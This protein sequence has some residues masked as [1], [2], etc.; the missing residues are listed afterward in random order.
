[1]SSGRAAQA[2]TTGPDSLIYAIGGTDSNKELAGL[3]ASLEAQF[4]TCRGG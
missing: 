1:M 3:L 2:A 4:K